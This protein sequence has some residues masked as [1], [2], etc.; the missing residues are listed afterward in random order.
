MQHTVEPVQFLR[1]EDMMKKFGLKSRA[2]F[3]RMRKRGDIP[4]PIIKSPPMW[5]EEDL[6][7]FYDERAKEIASNN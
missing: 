2:A 5:R 3:W 1:I 7:A 6:K 4:S